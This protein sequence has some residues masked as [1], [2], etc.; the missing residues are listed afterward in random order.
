MMKWWV[1]PQ[2]PA[3]AFLI[4]PNGGRVAFM[5]RARANGIAAALN[6]PEGKEAFENG[7]LG[8]DSER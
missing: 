2:G 1:E 6:T 7:R 5:S 8:H 4:N 3:T